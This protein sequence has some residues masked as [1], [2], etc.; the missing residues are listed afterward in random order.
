[1]AWP[2]TALGISENKILY[3]IVGV[4]SHFLRMWPG[5]RKMLPGSRKIFSPV[6]QQNL[7]Q[8]VSQIWPIYFH[9]T[10]AQDKTKKQKL[11]WAVS[12]TYSLFIMLRIKNHRQSQHMMRMSVVEGDIDSAFHFFCS[13]VAQDTTMQHV[14]K[15]GLLH[16]FVTVKDGLV[17]LKQTV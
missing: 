12:V 3:V 6:K 5:S 16:N 8:L 14:T 4:A 9:K 1:M 15:E 11:P 17:S 7:M 10:T 2:E 13:C